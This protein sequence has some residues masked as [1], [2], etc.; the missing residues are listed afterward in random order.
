MS[1]GKLRA[2]LVQEEGDAN[3]A[4]ALIIEE[5]LYSGSRGIDATTEATPILIDTMKQTRLSCP[6]SPILSLKRLKDTKSSMQV[7]F[8]APSGPI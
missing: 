5:G 6:P 3:T 1:N 7:A 4:E 8:L 2:V